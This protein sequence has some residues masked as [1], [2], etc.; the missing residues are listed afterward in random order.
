MAQ[1]QKRERRLE[2]QGMVCDGGA[3]VTAAAG[4]GVA[5]VSETDALGSAQQACAAGVGC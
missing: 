5:G 2:E 1:A 4:D 3:V